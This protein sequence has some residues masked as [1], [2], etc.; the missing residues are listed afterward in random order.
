MVGGEKLDVTVLEI[1]KLDLEYSSIRKSARMN[2][3]QERPKDSWFPR[4]A[5][6]SIGTTIQIARQMARSSAKTLIDNAV[7]FPSRQTRDSLKIRSA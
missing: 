4:S 3:R 5:Q 1:V 2:V 6:I 7:F